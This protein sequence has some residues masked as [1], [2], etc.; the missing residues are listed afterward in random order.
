MEGKNQ[1]AVLR[2]PPH[3]IQLEQ[4]LLGGCVVEGGQ[5][6]VALC[7]QKRVSAESFY[8][9]AHRIIFEE[10]YRVYQEGRPLNELILM[11]R[12][13]ATGKLGAAGGALYV[14]QICSRIDT[15]SHLTYYI[16]R[17][18]GYELMR[19]MISAAEMLVEKA[20]SNV[21]DVQQFLSEAEE[22][23]FSISKDVFQQ[24][25]QHIQEPIDQAVQQMQAQLQ[26]KGQLTGVGTGFEDLD[27]LTSG[28]HSGEM[29]VVAAR[30][31]MGK[32]SLALNIA[33][34]VILPKVGKPAIST[35]F[36]SLEM[37]ADQL[38]MRLLCSRAGIN[39]V[40]LREGYVPSGTLGELSRIA[41]EFRGAPFW[42]DESSSLTIV[43]MRARARR[44]HSR[45]PLGL[46]I[47]DYLQLV[48]GVDNRTP[49]EQQIAEISR[50]VKAMA[51]ELKVPVIVL[52]QLNRESEKERR[53]P[54]ISDLRE[55]G[56]I[57]QDADVVLLLAK[58]RDAD[59]EQE[60]SADRHHVMR[61]LIVAKQRNGP[62]GVVPLIFDRGLTKFQNCAESSYDNPS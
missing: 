47:I 40:Q 14:A 2:T 57:E 6:S 24:S 52:S 25:A 29:I 17:L 35:L 59:D 9:P 62:V 31:S 4:A 42:I 61:E 22:Q 37:G 48:S 3:N 60:L 10:I 19:R 54:R 8:Y 15:Q 50:G 16:D 43:E 56:S 7:L 58:A 23:V 26:R 32:T 55:S 45:H 1:G 12:L 13:T 30:P 44:I 11:E 33:E 18:R 46:V 36:F 49:R 20:Y 34:N 21:E 39:L 27:R 51:K 28:L 53:Q 41:Q 38:A 5:E